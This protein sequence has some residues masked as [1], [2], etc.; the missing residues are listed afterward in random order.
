MLT[1]KSIF[2]RFKKA[3]ENKHDFQHLSGPSRER[4]LADFGF[5]NRTKIGPES[6]SRAMKQQ[7]QKCLKTIG[8]SMFFVPPRDRK[9]IKNRPK[10]VSENILNEESKRA[11]KNDSKS[12]QHGSKIAPCWP[13]NPAQIRP[14]SFPRHPKSFKTLQDPPKTLPRHPKTP[15]DTPK[16]PQRHSQD[17]PHDPPRHSQDPPKILPRPSQDPPKTS[18]DPHKTSPNPPRPLPDSS[19]G[20]FWIPKST[21]N[22]SRIGLKSEEAKKAKMLKNHLLFNVF[23]ASEGSKINQKSIKNR[24]KKEFKM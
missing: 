24:S 4:F 22:Q 19:F 16:I 3:S 12:A 21:Q 23:C 15:Q 14:G 11:T 1:K 7:M 2:L 18:Q 5:Q 9:S 6:V 17:N 20:R 13:Q 10:I 8:F